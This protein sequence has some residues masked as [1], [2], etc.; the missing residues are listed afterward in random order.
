MI[1]VSPLFLKT[2]V[3][4]MERFNSV[5]CHF[6]TDKVCNIWP[7][8]PKYK[9]THNDNNGFV[10]TPLWRNYFLFSHVSVFNNNLWL[11]HDL[12]ILKNLA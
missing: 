7:F 8:S 12:C 5:L 2:A 6:L 3:F 11:L 1:I 9:K 10:A 4:K